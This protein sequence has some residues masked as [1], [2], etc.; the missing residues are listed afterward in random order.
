MALL[1]TTYNA[2]V[3]FARRCQPQA[4]TSKSAAAF[5]VLLHSNRFAF[6]FS[7]WLTFVPS[8]RSEHSKSVR[9]RLCVSCGLDRSRSKTQPSR[10]HFPHRA[11]CSAINIRTIYSSSSIQYSTTIHSSFANYYSWDCVK[12]H[13]NTRFAKQLTTT[14]TPYRRMIAIVINVAH[15][16]TQFSESVWILYVIHKEWRGINTNP[17]WCSENTCKHLWKD[18]YVGVGIWCRKIVETDRFCRIWNQW[19]ILKWINCVHK[20][21]FF[22]EFG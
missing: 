22:I 10:D 7:L 1:T 5:T 20:L 8:R 17:M 13:V 6:S 18:Q 3:D 15:K 14:T 4:R 9:R 2:F 21:D 19:N 16:R 12:S 11:G